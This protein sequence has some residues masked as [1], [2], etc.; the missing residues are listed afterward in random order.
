MLRSLVC[1][2]GI[3]CAVS[4][5]SSGCG[6]VALLRPCSCLCLAGPIPAVQVC[7]VLYTD[8]VVFSLHTAF[9]EEGCVSRYLSLGV[10]RV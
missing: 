9:C 4:G 8:R 3:S 2:G 1:L 10:G 5:L 6:F 7:C